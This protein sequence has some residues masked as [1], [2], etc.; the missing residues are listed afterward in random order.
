MARL[1]L[2][3]LLFLLSLLVVIPT[4]SH[5][6][7]YVT[8]MVTEFPWVFLSVI[9]ALMIWTFFSKKYKGPGAAMCV[10]SFIIFLYPIAGAYSIGHDLQQK[11]ERAF[12]PGSATLTG[13][14]Q[15]TP[16]SFTRM[17]SGIGDNKVSYT[18]YPY[19]VHTGVNLTLDFYR[20]QQPGKQPCIVIAHG[21]SWKSGNSHELPD[22]DWYLARQGYNVASI[23]YRLAP[24]YKSPAPI[25]DMDAALNYLKDH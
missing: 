24:V 25:E 1:S 13:L 11:F 22:I 14:Y 17:I 12:G 4:P 9:A 3:I 16:Y 15:P 21:G 18:T 8:I 10:I 7:W 5:Y 23:N 6:I 19:A 20:A 2:I